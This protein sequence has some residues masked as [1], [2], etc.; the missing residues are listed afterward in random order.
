MVIL[1]LLWITWCTIHSL[2]ISRSAHN[3]IKR[4]FPRFYSRYRFVYVC[5]SI[6]SLAPVLVCH[7]L[8]PEEIVVRGNLVIWSVQALLLGYAGFMF[9]AGS[10]VYNIRYFL[11]LEQW[12]KDRVRENNKTFPFYTDGVMAHVRHPWYSGGIAFLWGLGTITDVYLLTRIILT[13]YIL[14]GTLLEESRLKRDLG[15]QYLEYSRTVPM[16]IPWKS[17]KKR[18]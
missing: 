15:S 18:K 13:G 9:W 16:L 8:Q 10:R 6:V 4:F 12:K 3:T 1:A 5:F 7:F 17:L 14:V 11:G 2:L